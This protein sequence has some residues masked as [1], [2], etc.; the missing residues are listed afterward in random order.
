VIDADAAGGAERGRLRSASVLPAAPA[1]AVPEGAAPVALDAPRVLRH[2]SPARVAMVGLFVLAVIGVLAIGRTFFVP[3]TGAIMLAMVL[4]PLVARL[5]TV[6]VPRMGGAVL[7]IGA[8]ILGLFVA[9]EVLLDPLARLLDEIP[10]MQELLGRLTHVS[11]QLLGEPYGN[12]LKL[13][14]AE[15]AQQQGGTLSAHLFA[16]AAGASIGVATVILLAF[17]LLASGDHFLQKLVQAL[18]RIRD[19]V[20][21]VRI[22]RTVQDELSHYVATVA[23][24]NLALG[25]VTGLICWYFGLPNALL[26]GALVALFNFVPYVGPL[27]SFTLITIASFGTFPTVSQA[28]IVPLLFACITLVEGQVI[29]PMIVGRRVALNPVVV[30]VSL[31]FWAW[32]WGVAGM[33]LAVP[34]MLVVKIWAQ[35]TQVLAQWSEF[36]GPDTRN[37]SSKP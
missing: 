17:F 4:S 15:L 31:L 26:W 18:P 8:V 34:I 12:W 16:G 20:N 5:E 35:R 2:L 37:G 36:L 22:V 14:F 21:A 27:V 25:T 19:K 28:L 11:R 29:T 30:V 13:R 9:I 7:A 10:S 23:L 32:L 3:L 33:I 6:R 1:A 24:I